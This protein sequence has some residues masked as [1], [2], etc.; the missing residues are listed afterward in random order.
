ML[1]QV[2]T[3][4]FSAAHSFTSVKSQSASLTVPEQGARQ[5]NMRW[6]HNLL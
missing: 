1:T 5:I 6:Q 4:G 2:C 3:Q